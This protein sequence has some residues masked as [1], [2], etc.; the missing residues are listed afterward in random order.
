MSESKLTMEQK[1]DLLMLLQHRGMPLFMGLIDD[2]LERM[3]N[4][5]LTVP[6]PSDP[7]KAS[8]TLY[9]KRCSVEGAAALRA[10]LSAKVLKI[11]QTEGEK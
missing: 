10:A 8:L 4:E 2:I 6:L 5:M 7:E 9:A 11:K 1:E 3:R